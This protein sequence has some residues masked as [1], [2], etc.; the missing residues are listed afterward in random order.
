MSFALLKC[1]LILLFFGGTFL[2]C[3]ISYQKKIV[4]FTIWGEKK[5]KIK[6][7]NDVNFSVNKNN[8]N[9]NT[10]QINGKTIRCQRAYAQAISVGLKVGC[11]YQQ[12]IIF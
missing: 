4:I 10:S 8:K 12:T 9:K 5:Q 1:F 3:G 7:A 11:K 6:D 2:C